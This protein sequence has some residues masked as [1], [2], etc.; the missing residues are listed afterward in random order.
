MDDLNDAVDVAR[1]A[2][3]IT[4]LDHPDRARRLNNLG[5]RLSHRFERTG[6][7]DDLNDAVDVARQAVDATPLDHPDRARLLNNLG[8]WFGHRFGRT[9]SMDDINDAVDIARQAVD[10]T[11][12]DHP[13]R[14]GL[15]NNL[16][17][18]LGRRFERTG[19]MDDLN[20]AVDLARQA[21]DATPLDHP[22]RAG[23]LNNLGICLGR[24]FGRTGSMDDLNDAVDIAR[25]AVDATPLDHPDRA[26]LLNNLGICL[27]RRFERT[28]STDDL[29]LSHVSFKDLDLSVTSF[30]EAWSCRKAPPS[31]RIRAARN[32]ALILTLL[33]NWSGSSQLLQDAV[34]LLPLVSP[35]TLEHTDKQH[36]LGEFSGLASKAAAATLN[37]GKEAIHALELLELGRG[38][39]S[40]LLL[41]V[42]TDISALKEQHRHLAE[43]FE[44]LRDELDS[45]AD[46]TVE[47]IAPLA[48][49]KMDTVSTSES[50][51]KRRRDADQSFSELVTTIRSHPGFHNFL[52]PP[53]A[54][55]LMAAA[56]PDPIV[57]LNVH[58]IR[59]DAILIERN[60]IRTLELP[61]LTPQDIQERVQSLQSTRIIPILE[62]L[63]DVVARP[64]LDELGLDQPISDDNWPHVWWIPTGPLAR[65]PL[66]AAGRHVKGSTETVLDRVMSSYS[67]SIK[68][69][70]HGRRQRAAGP[71]ATH[72]VLVAMGETPGQDVLPSAVE[73]VKMLNDLC[74]SLNLQPVQPSPRKQDIL[75][76]LHTCRI[77]HFAGHG[78]S[79]PVEP[80][81]SR[82]LLSDWKTDPLTVRD[83]LD[84]RLQENAPFLG[85]LSA[86]STGVNKV[87]KLADEGIHLVSALQLAGFRHTIGTLWPIED[88]HCVKV[89]RA[90]YETIRDEGM[91]D[92]A[93]YRGFHRAVREL[94]SG[95]AE[96]GSGRGGRDATLVSSTPTG[97]LKS[98]ATEPNH[99][100]VPYVHFGV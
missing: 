2:V 40:G 85:Y 96:E 99:H 98:A 50:R 69:L 18:W 37:A 84:H 52:C 39:V 44:R 15:L 53:T 61:G 63:W 57:V 79:D 24:R 20:D 95:Q 92:A 13:D 42:R 22:D 89:A 46:D 1:Q 54:D 87:D 32:A 86:C 55:E 6:S 58:H 73:E 80:S 64:C 83:L 65:L 100:W 29:D 56:D 35:R 67:S 16:G 4:P 66:H 9:G 38:V 31:D 12:L 7:T 17:I 75:R 19:S 68:A 90:V 34:K 88:E 71:T 72:A 45:P 81:K 77:F 47:R 62:W 91:T 82:L 36:M 21:V 26:R 25:Q 97:S 60:R 27:G 14:V 74:P 76:H 23:R 93:I 94:R 28:G 3:D 48:P 33:Q 11:P 78:E 8:S 70:T 43:E 30:K 59:C 10:A 5:N 41:E 51:A 49:S